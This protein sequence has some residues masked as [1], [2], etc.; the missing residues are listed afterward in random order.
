MRWAVLAF[1]AAMAASGSAHPADTP[2]KVD[3]EAARRALAARSLEFPVKGYQPALRDNFSD[4]RRKATHEA[5]DIMAPRGTPVLA[6][7]DGE[8]AKLAES[9]D[10]GI[11]LY[12]YD[13]SQKLAYY[14]AH[15]DH[16][17]KG[18]K[19]GDRVKR[20]QV[21]G[22][23]GRTGNASAPH[24]HF[25]VYALGP[26]KRWWTGKAINPFERLM[27]ALSP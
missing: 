10:G 2:E 7:D 9:R 26:S 25:T 14:Y 27:T 22:Y 21:I 19:A 20:G 12:Q 1:F 11:T 3:V 15:L 8:I 13:P 17:A 16:Y 24:L 5:L 4:H 18:L 6:V 23:V